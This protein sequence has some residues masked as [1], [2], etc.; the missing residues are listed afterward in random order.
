MK[1][2]FSF[3]KCEGGD[4]NNLV[5]FKVIIFQKINYA[6]TPILRVSCETL[7][8]SKVE[9]ASSTTSLSVMHYK[10]CFNRPRS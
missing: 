1:I 4:K 7:Q 9:I 3:Q 2:K 10:Q 5:T 8:D 6:C